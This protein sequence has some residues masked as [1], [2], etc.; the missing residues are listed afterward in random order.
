VGGRALLLLAAVRV[1]ASWIDSP[2]D[3]GPLGDD[4]QTPPW[5]AGRRPSAALSAIIPGR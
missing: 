4:M 5:M 1:Q 3:D 2:G